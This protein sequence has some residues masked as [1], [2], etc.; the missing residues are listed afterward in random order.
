[1]TCHNKVTYF[2]PGKLAMDKSMKRKFSD[3]NRTFNASWK[4]LFAF[5]ADKTGLSVCLI[6][7]EK[8]ANNK[9]SN[10]K[11]HFQNKHTAFAE[12]NIQLEM[13]EEEQFRNCCGKLI[14]AKLFSSRG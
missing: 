9:K 6:C 4:D 10:L 1:M 5:T 3:E 14:R 7:A 8:L 11:R 2:D 12:K 13:N